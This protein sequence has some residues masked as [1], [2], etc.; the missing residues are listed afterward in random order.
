MGD[1]SISRLEFEHFIAEFEAFRDT[2]FDEVADLRQKIELIEETLKEIKRKK[3][4]L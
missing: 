2:F 3:D 4:P 1:E